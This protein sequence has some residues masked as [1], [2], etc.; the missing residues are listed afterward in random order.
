MS[1]DAV[2]ADGGD[3][4]DEQPETTPDTLTT[5][6]EAS[7]LQ[8]AVDILL[9]VADECI[10]NLGRDGLDVALVDPAN[11]YMAELSLSE[12]AFDS[13]GD[14]HFAIGI[15]LD[16]IDDILGKADADDLIELVLDLETRKFHIEFGNV[17]MDIAGIDPESVRQEPDISE[18]ELPN[19][20]DAESRHV[21]RAVDICK[22]VSDH[23]A[24]EGDT[25]AECIRFQADGDIDDAQVELTDELAFADV[26]EDVS[27][28]FSIGTTT[29]AGPTNG[30]LD[31][32]L[33]PVPKSTEVTV[34]FGDE[35]P[36]FIEWEFADGD[37]EVVQMIAPRIKSQ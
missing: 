15:S 21:K 31:D 35:F 16:R 14:G 2:E 10:F 11:V 32:A 23:A 1:A 37:G 12:S 20:F 9:S 29:G 7:K 4:S 30:Y 5:V 36:V 33:K 26:T 18:I 3:E 22:M 28:L 13:V 25:D 6:I 8:T 34:R 24:I 19:R 27:S 17:E